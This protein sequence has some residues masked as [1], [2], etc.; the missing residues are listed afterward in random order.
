MDQTYDVVVLGTGLKECLVAGVLSAVERMKV[1]HVDRNDYYGGESASLNLLQVFEK[2]AK[3]RAM[4]KSAI[5][6]KYGRYQDYNIDLIPKYI[7]GN[8]L[9]TKVLV[10][11]GVHQYIQFRAGDGSFVVGKGGKIHKVPANDKEALRSSLMGMF[12]KL[13]ARSFFVFVQNFVETDPSTHGGY[14]LHRMPA[15]EL[16]EKF[17]LAAETVEFIG[18]ALA[19]KTN[20]RYLDEPA[21]NLVKAVRLYSDSMARFDTGSPYIYPLY[22]LGELPQGFARLSAVYGGTYML[23]KHDVEV[24]YDEETGRACG[25]KSEGETAKAKF[26]VG[27]PSYFPGKTKVMGQVVRALCLLSHPIPNVNDAESVQIIIPAAQCGRRHDVYVLGAGSSHN[28][29]AKGRYFASLEVGLRMLGPI[30]ELF[31]S[32]SDVHHPLADGVAD[33]AFI[34]TGYDATTHFETTVRD[35]IDIYKR[36]TGKDLDLSKDDFTAAD[37]SG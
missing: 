14:N 29:C 19:L 7:M 4:D 26:V 15:R 37:T 13:R 22:G 8:G 34:S 3:E 27:D 33:G 32:V 5:A 23:A 28:V 21:V 25:V 17:G 6:A 10:K 36:I 1:L 2:F 24:V 20:E 12:E 30:D 31:Y 18:H 35:V 9:L 11:T 16:Y